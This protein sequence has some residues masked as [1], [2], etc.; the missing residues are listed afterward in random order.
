MDQFHL[1]EVEFLKINSKDLKLKIENL[2]EIEIFLQ[3]FKDLAKKLKMKV[4]F[5][6]GS[7][8]YLSFTEYKVMKYF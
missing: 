5:E 4:P 8:G 3:K 2:N 7:Y 6:N 1:L